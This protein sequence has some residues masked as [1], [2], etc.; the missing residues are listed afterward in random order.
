MPSAAEKRF[1]ALA[2]TTR[3]NSDSRNDVILK[4][5]HSMRL[6]G[7]FSLIGLLLVLP[8][9]LASTMLFRSMSEG[10]DFASAEVV[11]LEQHMTYRKLL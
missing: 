5:L 9:M 8:L 7:K 3:V 4:A 6:S 10:I 1:Q 2:A 11:G